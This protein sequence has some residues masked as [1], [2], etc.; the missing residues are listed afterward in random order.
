LPQNAGS[1]ASSGSASAAA[2]PALTAASD[3]KSLSETLKAREALSLA[4]AAAESKGA[5][6]TV[7]GLETYAEAIDPEWKRQDDDRQQDRR[8]RN[9][10]DRGEKDSLKT[11]S[12]TADMLKK[13]SL[14]YMEKNPLL[15]ILNKLPGKNKQRWI[16]LPFDFF[17]DEKHFKV[18]LRIMLDERNVSG[19]AVRMAMQIAVNKKQL[20]DDADF[21]KKWLFVLDSA[22]GKIGKTAVY[23]L[24]EMTDKEQSRFKKELSEAL[25][26]PVKNIYVKSGGAHKEGGESFPCEAGCDEQIPAIDEAV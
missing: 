24:N 11:E 13:M 21:E 6:L 2:S 5:E 14:E 20:T 18:S 1:A 8:K 23:L 19:C 3:L 7:K 10:N 12:V 9:Q 15:E 22:D 4:A 16:V 17:E 25:E 26:I